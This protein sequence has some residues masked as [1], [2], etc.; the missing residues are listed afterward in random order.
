MNDTAGY[1]GRAMSIRNLGFDRT[2]YAGS[3]WKDVLDE[4]WMTLRDRLAVRPRY[5]TG[6]PNSLLVRDNRCLESADAAAMP[7]QTDH[8]VTE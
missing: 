2:T 7:K 1:F 8:A 4:G 6:G 3:K 5:R